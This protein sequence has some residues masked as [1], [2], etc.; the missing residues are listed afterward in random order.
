M[1]AHSGVRNFFS[2]FPVPFDRGVIH[3]SLL[4]VL[5]RL[6]IACGR[7]QDAGGSRGVSGSW[8]RSNRLLGALHQGLG[9]VDAVTIALM[10]AFTGS[11][12]SAHAVRMAESRGSAESKPESNRARSS[13]VVKNA[14]FCRVS[15]S[16]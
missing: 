1:P 15:E 14:L 6:E 8:S 7:V 3:H 10:P 11:G 12:R 2:L 4:N 9:F 16:A 5:N 13:S